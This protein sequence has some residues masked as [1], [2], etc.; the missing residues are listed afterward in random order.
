MRKAACLKADASEHWTTLQL[1]KFSITSIPD[2]TEIIPFIDSVLCNKK[3]K[4]KFDWEVKSDA[5]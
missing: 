2:L 5:T 4:F 1:F 3:I